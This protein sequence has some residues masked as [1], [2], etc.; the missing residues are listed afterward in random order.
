VSTVYLVLCFIPILAFSVTYNTSSMPAVT[1]R[2]KD[3]WVLE[4]G[5]ITGFFWLCRNIQYFHHS[6]S[7]VPKLAFFDHELLTLQFGQRPADRAYAYIDCSRYFT[8][9]FQRILANMQK[10]QFSRLST[11]LT[12]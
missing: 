3:N 8:S 12:A 1:Q 4:H 2:P 11:D 10:Y 7:D 9:R 6:W 5:R